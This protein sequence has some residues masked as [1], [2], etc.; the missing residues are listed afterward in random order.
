MQAQKNKGSFQQKARVN[1][2][3]NLVNKPVYE[4]LNQPS[5]KNQKSSPKHLEKFFVE[6]IFEK[7][8]LML[9]TSCKVAYK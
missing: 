1:A 5:V 8:A 4:Y 7:R 3:M 9:R 2:D 6:T